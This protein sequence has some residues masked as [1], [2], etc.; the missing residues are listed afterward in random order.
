MQARL[1]DCLG[2]GL[3]RAVKRATF[4][5]SAA[6]K[7]L[8]IPLCIQHNSLS[9]VFKQYLETSQQCKMEMTKIV[10]SIGL[11]SISF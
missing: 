5:L 6:A 11:A 3:Y 4:E 1:V 10:S 2:G 8:T 9:V 7:K